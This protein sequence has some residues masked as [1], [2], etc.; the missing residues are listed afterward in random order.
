MIHNQVE[1]IP[2]GQHPMVTR[3]LKGVHNSRPPQPRYTQTWDVDV[4]IKYICSMGDNK[5]LSLKTLSL[6]LAILMA[7]VDA[8]RT[9][10]LAAL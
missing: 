5:E 8:S 7:L 9:S 2:I 6:K 4:V 3:L 10:E 1:G